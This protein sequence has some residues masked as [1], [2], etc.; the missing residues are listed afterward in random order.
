MEAEMD[1]IIKQILDFK[2]KDIP[3][4][5]PHLMMGGG[6]PGVNL[7]KGENI[8]V[9]DINGNKYIDCTSQSWALHLGYNHPDIKQ[10]MKNGLDHYGTGSGSAHLIS[11]HSR[12][13]HA[14]EEEL[15]DFCGYPR[16]L[17]FSTGYMANLG[18]AQ[19]L[20][21]QGDAIFE[22]RLNHASLLDAALL[23]GARL[24]RYA[25]LDVADLDNKLSS[26]K[27]AEKLV[28]TDGV[29]S[30][31]GDTAPVGKL[32]EIC[33]QHQAW[34]MVD[35]A[36]GFGVVGQQGKGSLEQLNIPPDRVPVYMATLGKAAGR[37]IAWF[38]I[39][40][41]GIWKSLQ[42]EGEPKGTPGIPSG[43]CY[44]TGICRCGPQRRD[45]PLH[46]SAH[47]GLHGWSHPWI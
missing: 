9:Y 6:T 5:E 12:A 40:N 42:E 19:A 39:G 38:G 2:E 29:F 10:A 20:C 22:D 3:E 44:C 47:P 43:G 46:R 32:A 14:L 30:M 8:Y 11:G 4:Y 25:H 31:D 35:D 33:H 21:S 36:H 17:L 27:K 15:A 23:S 7:V 41:V 24:Q 34:L 1:T 28:M 13:H 45:Y 37:Q 26:S 18:I 16:A